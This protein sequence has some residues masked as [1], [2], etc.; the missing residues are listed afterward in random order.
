MSLPAEPLLLVVDDD[1]G[2]RKLLKTSLER[3][4]FR[5]LLGENGVHALEV[6][7]EADGP[8]ALLLSDVVMPGMGGVDLAAKLLAM[9]APPKVMLMSGYPHDPALLRVAGT[10]PPFLRKPFN[11]PDVVKRIRVELGIAD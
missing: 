9:P 4:G 10:N 8:I 3:A 5:V 1:P 7:A 6:L 2:V 11:P